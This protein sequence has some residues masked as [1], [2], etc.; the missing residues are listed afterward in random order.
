MSLDVPPEQRRE[1]QTFCPLCVSRCGATATVAD[2]R[3]IELRPDP[4]HPTGHALCVK[5]KAAPEIVAHPDRL[6][7]PMR[8]T[9]PKDADD[10][11]WSRISWDEALDEI[12]TRLTGI[13]REH[14]PEGVVFG[15]SSPSTSAMSDSVDWLMRLKNAF[16]SPNL[17]A[18]MELCGW[19]R[20]FASAFT[21][22]APL[23]GAYA[24]DLANAGCILFWGYN[25]S[26]SRLVHATQAVAALRRGAQL[27]VV[28]PREVGLAAK[29]QHWLR[30][31]P[32]T[33]A[34]LALAMTHVLIENGWYDEEFVRRWTN[35]PFLVRSDTGQLLPPDEDVRTA[36]L[37]GQVEVMTPDGPVPCRPVFD[38]I[39]EKCAALAPVVAADITGVPAADIVQAAR[40]VWEARPLALYTWSGL[41]QHSNSTQTV[42]A[43]CQLAALVGSIDAPG[44]NVLFPSVPA[45]RIDGTE[46]LAREQSAKAIGLEKRPLSAARAGFVTGE[47]LFTAALDGEPYRVRALVNFGANLMMA[48]GN[49]A[50]GRAALAALEFFV[51]AD[52]FLSPTAEQADLV[53]PVTS[54][55]EAEALR[56]GFEVDEEAQS[57][58]QLRTQLVPARGEARSD[59]QIIFGLAARLGLGEVFFGGDV[60]AAWRHQLEPS[61]VTLEQLRAQPGGVRVPLTTRHRKYAELVDGVP[62]GFATPSRKVE[63]FSEAFARNGYPPLPEYAEPG[64]SPRSR[65]DL[66]ERYPLVLTCAKSL[67]F[68]ETQHRNVASLRRAAPDP[69]VEIHPDAARARGIAAKD[70]VLIETPLGTVRARAKLNGRLDPQVV[71][72]Q[73]GWWQAS[74]DNDRPGYPAVGPG[75]ANLNLVLSQTPSDPVGGSSPL[76]AGLCEIRPLVELQ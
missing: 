14:G 3:L 21:F 66:A 55:W 47:D 51:H 46:L 50:R 6:L 39:A 25:P 4:G 17:A 58:V 48:H 20:Y 35:A 40:L 19:G 24:P 34:A 60:E 12:A 74:V 28:D 27:V 22:G 7:Y 67:W 31:R 76:R 16:G 30:V 41:E 70:W 2:G 49:S 38:L 57:L 59:L 72:G 45:H 63:L 68:C 15:S 1:V 43:I 62:R 61:G 73:H 13:A 26:I 33:D 54:A 11:G 32:G 69:I 18:S 53:L 65:P 44:G 5:G 64:I 29:A 23:P 71:C 37:R 75:S 56:I 42:R 36:P 52:L 10:P 8:R 9:R